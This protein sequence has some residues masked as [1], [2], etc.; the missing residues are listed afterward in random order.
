MD[1]DNVDVEWHPFIDLVALF[2]V[3]FEGWRR[4]DPLGESTQEAR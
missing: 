4:A 2:K 3:G 1:N